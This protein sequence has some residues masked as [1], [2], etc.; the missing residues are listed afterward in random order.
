MA[1]YD[2]D[3]D[4]APEEPDYGN[5]VREEQSLIRGERRQAEKRARAAEGAKYAAK[6]W[7]EI[8]E[9]LRRAA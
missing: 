2:G 7:A 9:S 8:L 6:L 5:Y 4:F 1:V 3:E